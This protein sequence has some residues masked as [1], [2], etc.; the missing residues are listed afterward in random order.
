MHVSAAAA[1]QLAVPMGS[2]ADVAMRQ[3]PNSNERQLIASWPHC[4]IAS[5]H[6]EV[7]SLHRCAVEH[8]V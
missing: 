2:R 1:A 8:L 4:L 5:L 3:I 6:H 7:L